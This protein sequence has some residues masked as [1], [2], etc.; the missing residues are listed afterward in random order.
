[1]ADEAALRAD[2]VRIGGLMYD[3]QL[4]VA[5]EGN[6]SARLGG[7]RFL[8]SPAG[9]CKGQLAAADPVAVDLQGRPVD[10]AAGPARPSSEWRLHRE[11]Y[12]VRPDVAAICHGHP[13]WATAFAA[14]GQA[15]DG[16]LLPEVVATLGAVPLAPYATPGTEEVPRAVRDLI[17]GHD[18]LLLANHGVVAVG[19]TLTEAFFRLETVERLAQV[20]LL[21][22]LAGGERRLGVA[23]VAALRGDRDAP[24]APAPCVTG[25]SPPPAGLDAL[26]EG[27]VR[28]ILQGLARR[29]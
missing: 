4:V 1:M 24:S 15:L 12:G 6:L 5:A 18:A 17:A 2:M 16:C 10:A 13:A 21:A 11:I 3:R 14:A 29:V 27:L 28:G 25:N 19:A 9:R 23:E 20:T 22:R 8:V 7:D 26:A